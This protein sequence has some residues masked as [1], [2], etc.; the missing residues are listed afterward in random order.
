MA[1]LIADGLRVTSDQQRARAWELHTYDVMLGS[2]DLLAAVA[3][4]QTGARGF[5]ITRQPAYLQPFDRGSRASEVLLDRLE[6]LTR[7]NPRQVSRVAVL[8]DEVEHY[9]EQLRVNIDKARAGDPSAAIQSLQSGDDKRAMDAIRVRVGLFAAEEERLLT[10]RAART[11]ADERAARFAMYLLSGA[12]LLLLVIAV[13]AVVLA[14]RSAARLRLAAVERRAAEDLEQA[15]DFLLAVVDGAPDP[16][17]AKDLEGRY[18]LAN[19]ETARIFGL[20]RDGIIGRRDADLVDPAV[21]A[22]LTA[23]DRRVIE[24]GRAE[25]IEEQVHDGGELRTYQSSKAPWRREGVAL[26]VI[27][28]SRD[29]TERKLAE[30]ALRELNNELEARVEA[31]TREIERAEAQI[32]QMQKMESIGQL[33][34]GIAHDFNNMLAI[35]IGSLDIARRRILDDPEKAASFI[36]NAREGADRAASLTSRMLAFA[37]QQP[38]TPVSLDANALIANMSELLRRTLGEHVRI[39]TV[40]AGGLWR[41]TADAGELEN[42][43]LN[44]CVNARD[45]MPDGGKLTIETANAHLDDA[46][47]AAHPDVAPGQYVLICVS[48]N[49]SGMTPEVIEKAF[50]PYFTTKQVGRGTGLGLSQVYG[51]IKQS[52][53]HVKIY[54]EVGSGTTVKAYLPRGYGAEAGQGPV[55]MRREQ[56]A[57]ARPGEIVLV[58]EDESGVRTLSVDALR[59]LGY[60]VIHADGGPEGLRM[61]DKH[62]KV[63]LLFT[64]VV[65]PE[66]NGR[67]LA[68]RAVARRPELKVLYTTGY[69][70][71]AVVHNGVLDPGVAL[72]PKPFTLDQLALKV[73]QVLD[74]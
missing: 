22:A 49:G 71:N 18:L 69:T 7:D 2:K 46:Y 37:R 39:E 40:L 14:S 53:G 26:G 57:T 32:R 68:D 43:L 23:A 59:E 36:D 29:I 17:Y 72:L 58:V 67:Q 19:A 8:R 4:T 41:A 55:E 70:R 33:T 48:D 25:V 31:R 66:M 44:L 13:G 50:D 54:S 21:A 38:L 11:V 16:I 10:G 51:F 56:V 74:A 9:V 34:G 24:S 5:L 62:P 28:V 3:D 15:R 47:A 6:R 64:D 20:D 45:A 30:I 35:V 61:L 63:D 65:M 1:F 52:G 27:G 12:G 60:T 73:R 42:A